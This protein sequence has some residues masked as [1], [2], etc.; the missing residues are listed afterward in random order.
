MGRAASFHSVTNPRT[1]W[2]LSVRAGKVQSAAR[3][4]IHLW[5][6]LIDSST[7]RCMYLD[8]VTRLGK[9]R[10]RKTG[11]KPVLRFYPV[12]LAL[13]VKSGDALARF[14]RFSRLYVI[15]E[16]EIDVAL[17]GMPPELIH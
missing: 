1:Y 11:W 2:N 6:E 13:F 12:W 3:R 16:R 10:G 15:F 17:H 14:V 5:R 9:M 8:V 7:W 4:Q